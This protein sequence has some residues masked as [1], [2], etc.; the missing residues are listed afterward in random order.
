MEGH[1]M[2]HFYDTRGRDRTLYEA[3]TR[4]NYFPNQKSTICELPPSINSR[5][6]TPEVAEALAVL[7]EKKGRHGYDLVEYKA[8]RYNN[9]PRVLGIVH[10]K[11]YAM[12]AKCIHDNWHELHFLTLNNNSMI[13]PE[14]YHEEKR[15]M[16]MNYED[17]IVKVTRSHRMGFAKRF[18]VQA[19]VTNCFNSIYSHSIP[20]AALGVAAAKAQKN[21]K[22]LWC[23]KLDEYQRKTKRNET[24]GIPIGPATSSIVSELILGCV[25]RDLR[26]KGYEFCRYIDDYTCY[27]ETDD[28]AQE[29]I[30]TLAASLATYKLSLNLKKTVIDSLPCP[31]ED[32]W[33]LELRG[34]LPSRLSHA[35]SEE[36]KIS[37]TE[38]LTFLNR[39]IEVN[40][41]TPDG[42]VLKYAVSL[43]F[44]HLDETVPL[45][46]IDP[47]L[48]LAWHFPALLPFVDLIVQ[49][50][51][52]AIAPYQDQL[53][54]IIKHN[55]NMGRSDGMAWPLHSM[56]QAGITVDGETADHVLNSRDCI[57]I[58]LLLEMKIHEPKII[59]LANSLIQSADDYEK[60]TYWLLFYQLFMRGLINDPY[61][62]GVFDCLKGF[63]VNFVP[64]DK[65]SKAEMRS[66]EIFGQIESEALKHIFEAVLPLK[67]AQSA[68]G[69]ENEKNLPL[70]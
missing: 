66:D 34:A 47:L 45:D 42:S 41:S 58:T 26:D 15:L 39:A 65:K 51:P 4:Y 25:D 38:A 57:A 22:T 10:P 7:P 53:S 20:W 69:D 54:A 62:D 44:S 28:Q 56:L 33:V 40:K 19:D 6:F 49:K 18:R 23:N 32:S 67:A 5:R 14:F 30:R 37:T 64:D 17:P 21:D 9:V 63:D 43:I 52:V 13:K 70:F 35:H 55:A 46:L 31:V 27:C 1:L 2:S 59:D 68:I 8:T 12:L 61:A 48:N 36:P 24:Q 50:T 60:D 3:L 16:V 11:A 29:F